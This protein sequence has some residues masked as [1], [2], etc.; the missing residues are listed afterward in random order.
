[1]FNDLLR[2]HASETAPALRHLIIEYERMEIRGNVFQRVHQHLTWL[3]RD[4][5]A[6]IERL[7]AIRRGEL[8]VHTDASIAGDL[9]L[10][11]TDIAFHLQ[12]LQDLI[13]IVPA[14]ELAFRGAFRTFSRALH[15][16]LRVGYNELLPR[17]VALSRRPPGAAEAN[18][19]SSQ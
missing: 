7:N 15:H 17:I 11:Y 13:R 9:T 14:T 16:Y 18:L 12:E 2:H 6:H 10:A 8:D 1:M 3:A 19:S 5:D 4:L